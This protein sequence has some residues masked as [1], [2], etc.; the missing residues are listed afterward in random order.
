MNSPQI[1]IITV[2]RN[3]LH[4]MIATLE[5]VQRQTFS[6][7]EHIVVDGASSDGTAEF[8]KNNA[9]R[10][11]VLISEPDEG[12][13]DAMNKGAEKASG[14]WV[15]YMNAGDFFYDD[16]TLSIINQHLVIKDTVYFGRAHIEP[17]TGNGWS[18]P[19]KC[20]SKNNIRFWL[21]N[22]LPNHQAI[23]FP[24]SFYR[25]HSYR[26]DLQI[27]A[28]SEYKERALLLE[29]WEFIDETV[30]LFQLTGVSSELSLRKQV[31]QSL[32]RFNRLSGVE[33][34]IDF[35]IS[36]SKGLVR[37]L[38]HVLIGKYSKRVLY[39]IKSRVDCLRVFIRSVFVA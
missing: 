1:S 33:K 11:A 18:Y 2:V 27:S 14:D 29:R 10:I 39:L 35:P 16:D 20:V 31:Q 5:S 25:D 38:S 7:I 28:D 12:I 22:N 17:L 32:D 19:P 37:I 9:A 8:L 26:L 6:D 21:R 4:G 3:D 13:Y 15:I 34:Y 30:C 24:R 36:L 23:F